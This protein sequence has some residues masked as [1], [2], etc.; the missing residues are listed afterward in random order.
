VSLASVC[1]QY[2]A[3]LAVMDGLDLDLASRYLV[4]AATLLF[5]KSKQ[6]LP[7]APAPFADALEDEAAMAEQA[8]R[9]RLI[10]YQ[11]FKRAGA[12]L[13]ERLAANAAYHPSAVAPDD[14]LVQHYR[15]ESPALAL[16]IENVMEHV[17]ARPAV[18]KRETFSMVVKMNYVLRRLKEQLT[19]AFSELVAG[20]G[21]LEIAV[22]F[23]A[24]LELVR[25]RRI[26][27]VQPRAFEDI[28]IVRAP[29]EAHK[30]LGKSA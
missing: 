5:I 7:P 4:I 6:L 27:C 3:Y 9:E 22:T 14:S 18:V 26:Q 25:L 11:H 21:R 2:L 12:D 16:A 15:L 28:S 24:L 19:L 23:F 29:K 10:A 8:L 20:C 17:Q 30:P 13:R 1:E